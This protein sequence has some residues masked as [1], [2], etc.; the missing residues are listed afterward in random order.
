[1]LEAALAAYKRDLFP[2]SARAAAESAANLDLSF[3]PDAPHGI[4]DFFRH[5]ENT[6]A[7]TRQ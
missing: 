7:S 3:A 5:L 2:R 1:M 4:L 6:A